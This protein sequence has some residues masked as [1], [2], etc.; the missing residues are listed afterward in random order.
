MVD[1]DQIIVDVKNVLSVKK[2]NR[3]LA[4]EF[5]DIKIIQDPLYRRNKST[6]DLEKAVSLFFATQ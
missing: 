6:I 5:C 4:A 2:D 3:S 1:V